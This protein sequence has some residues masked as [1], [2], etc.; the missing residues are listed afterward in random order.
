[1]PA[2]DHTGVAARDAQPFL[3]FAR[4]GICELYVGLPLLLVQTLTYGVYP[5]AAG[6]V[7]V[8]ASVVGG[9]SGAPFKELAAW[10][11]TLN[12]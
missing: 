6:K 1:M 12:T 4:H 11:M 10:E 2:R 9:D 7:G 3:F 5:V 8:A